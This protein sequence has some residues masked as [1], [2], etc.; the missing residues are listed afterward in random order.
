MYNIST[1]S[2]KIYNITNDNKSKL[3]SSVKLELRRTD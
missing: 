2:D 3:V 1:V